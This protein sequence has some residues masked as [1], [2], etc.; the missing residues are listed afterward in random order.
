MISAIDY[1]IKEIRNQIP[2][3]MLTLAFQSNLPYYQQTT[4]EE[5]ILNKVIRTRVYDDCNLVGG[6]YKEIILKP[7]YMEK[8]DRDSSTL[9]SNIGPCSIYRIPP[10]ARENL[11]ISGVIELQWPGCQNGYGIPYTGYYSGNNIRTAAQKMLDAQTLRSTP[12]KP[13]VE[14]L[15]GDL[16]RLNPSQHNTQNWVLLVRLQ[17]DPNM[18][19]L[20]ASAIKI[21]GQLCVAATKAYIHNKLVIETDQAFIEAGAELGRVKEYIDKYEEAEE[22]YQELVDK[23]HGVAKMDPMLWKHLL[24]KCMQ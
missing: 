15:S 21:Y 7:E 24:F 5:M 10:E 8:F 11:P 20:N 23:F 3:R 18:T 13:T 1:A 14:V 4:L 19:N 12:P 6:K 17:F 2:E 9:V 22:R 16:V